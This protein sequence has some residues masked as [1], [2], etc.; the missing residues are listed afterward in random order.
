MNVALPAFLIFLFILPGLIFNLSFYNTENTPLRYVS[1]THKAI[2]SS[3]ITI[4]SHTIWLVLII[5]F[6]HYQIDIHLLLL[7][8]A[9]VQGEKFA[10]AI[11]EVTT[12]E[13]IIT[14]YY[15]L[16][17]YVITYVA[18]ISL[19]WIIRYFRLDEQF[20]FLRI[21]SPWYYLFTGSDWKD[22]KPDGVSIAAIV[23]IGGKGY[24]YVGWLEN[25]Y[26]DSQGNIDRLVLTSVMRREI[27]HD[28]KSPDTNNERFYSIDGD[29]FVLKYTEVKSLNV[30]FIKLEEYC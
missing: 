6:F 10:S 17:M 20:S 3:A 25:F 7:L 12:N 14:S 28:K 5:Y 19:R 21:D 24:L 16:S 27:N 9:G 1:L 29:Y 18:G 23:E 8:V 15:L 30:Q 4:I 2:I 26:L 13:I 22:G 11:S